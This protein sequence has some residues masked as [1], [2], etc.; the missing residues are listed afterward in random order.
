VGP[1]G[2]GAPGILA[3]ADRDRF[4]GLLEDAGFTD[5]RFD[6]VRVA[7]TFDSVDE[8]WTF[9]TEA[10]GAIATERAGLDDGERRDVRDELSSLVSPSGSG[11]IHLPALVVVAAAH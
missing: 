4:G 9:L 8:Y 11:E 7:W 5:V 6:D 1:P 3:F 2:V 10:A